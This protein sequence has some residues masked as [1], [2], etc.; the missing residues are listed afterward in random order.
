M[1]KLLKPLAG[2]SLLAV[3]AVLA[4]PL[5][6]DPNDYRDEIAARV[7]AATGHELTIAG[8]LGL[9]LFPRLGL[10]VGEA[11]IASPPGFGDEPILGAARIELSAR[12]IPLLQRRLE[13]ERVRIEGLRVHLIRDAEGRTNWQRLPPGALAAGVLAPAIAPPATEALAQ[14]QP[15]AQAAAPPA[16]GGPVPPTGPTPAMPFVLEAVEVVDGEVLWDDRLTRRRLALRDLRIEAGPVRPGTPMDLRLSGA[17]SDLGAGAQTLVTGQARL[18]VGAQ[19]MRIED[20]EIQVDVSGGA[21][22]AGRVTAE[23]RAEATL[24]L[25]AGTL[26]VAD[27]DLRSGDLH[28]AGEIAGQGLDAE[29]VFTGRLALAE[30]DLRTWLRERQIAIPPMADPGTLGR[31][32]LTTDWRL[33]AGRLDADP[34]ELRLDETQV[35]GTAAVL[36]GLTPGYRLALT[37]DRI[38]L[39][40]YLPPQA[41]PTTAGSVP[42][43]AETAEGPAPVPGW[44]AAVA[45]APATPPAVAQLQPRAE[46]RQLD[47]D[48]TLKIDELRLARLVFGAADLRLAAQGGQLQLD[49]RIG[50][51]YEG[52]LEGRIGLDRRDAQPAWT[53]A[54]RATGVAV[55]P[56]LTDLTGSAQLTGSG[57]ASAD[58]SARGETTDALVRSASGRLTLALRDGR[59]QGVDLE[60]LIAAAQARLGQGGGQGTAE[61]TRFSQLTATATVDQGVLHNED[62]VATSDH[63]RVTGQGRIDL[64]AER[65]DYRFEPVFVRPPQGRGIKE[66]EGIPIPVRLTGT[67]DQPVWNVDLAAALRAAGQRRLEQELGSEDGA[68]K[69]LEEGTGIKGLEQGLRRLFQR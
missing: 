47:L 33:A 18:P 12:L 2:L 23:A 22:G 36:P 38:D 30:L 25:A 48:G 8:D 67:F 68:L 63:L 27:L 69:R 60:G 56:L 35:R 15:L 9:S 59:V 24:D 51:F 39:D 26:H 46:A 16:S 11:S 14:A 54:Q 64:P 19:P 10:S 37:A 52:R 41:E 29:P 1:S 3:L 42:T 44:W 6:I 28:L 49:N 5:L 66:L 34:V 61:H 58:L 4:L 20:I 62:L 32:A 55:A 31:V 13:V 45:A 17:T 57:D 40:R 43:S 50:R 21:L 7:A 53:L 65:L